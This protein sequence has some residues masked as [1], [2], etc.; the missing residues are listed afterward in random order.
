MWFLAIAAGTVI[1]IAALTPAR[2]MR[3]AGRPATGKFTVSASLPLSAA[4]LWI[5]LGLAFTMS[6]G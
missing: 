2:R 6:T 3:R 4:A 1:L 5:A